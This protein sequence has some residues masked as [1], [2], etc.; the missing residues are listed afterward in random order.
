MSAEISVATIGAIA[1][2]TAAIIGLFVAIATAKIAK[3]QKV[4]EFRQIWINDLRSDMALALKNAYK[5]CYMRQEH[6]NVPFE[7]QDEFIN[8][9][10]EY[11]TEFELRIM[12]TKL[13]LNPTKDK[14]FI[15]LAEQSLVKVHQI[16]VYSTPEVLKQ[17][18]NAANEVLKSLE[19]GTHLILKNEWER[20][21]RGETRFL[22][23]LTTSE[24]LGGLFII[25]FY[26]LLALVKFP[27]YFPGI[28]NLAATAESLRSII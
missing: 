16:N 27:N 10:N 12:L 4:S 11:Y 19:S 26:V 6:R 8:S 1:A 18:Y 14:E 13:K 3:E 28:E 25:A 22:I 7:K 21:K 5:C 17:Q 15:E 23:Y 20:V 2:I 24:A 9:M